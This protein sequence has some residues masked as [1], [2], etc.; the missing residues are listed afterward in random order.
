MTISVLPT[1]HSLVFFILPIQAVNLKNVIFFFR[2]V[3]IQ[4]CKHLIIYQWSQ[5]WERVER[6]SVLSAD[7]FLSTFSS[8]VLS[9]VVKNNPLLHVFPSALCCKIIKAL[10]S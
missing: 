8:G 7:L 10:V 2:S 6:A 5:D 3:G 1:D 4:L 9:L